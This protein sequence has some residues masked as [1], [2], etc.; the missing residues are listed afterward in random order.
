VA[1]PIKFHGY[2]GVSWM[3][4]NALPEGMQRTI[5]H[6]T[7]HDILQNVHR[8]K[9]SRVGRC[10][11]SM[12]CPCCTENYSNPPFLSCLLPAAPCCIALCRQGQS[13]AVRAEEHHPACHP[14][15]SYQSAVRRRPCAA[16][17]V[18]A[19]SLSA[20][21]HM[22]THTNTSAYS[23]YSMCSTRWCCLACLT[24]PHSTSIV[25]SNKLIHSISPCCLCVPPL[26]LTQ[27]GRAA[28]CTI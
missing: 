18:S 1:N 20:G 10:E 19:L 11:M 3:L 28:A 7:T 13:G 2:Q 5:L 26:A 15:A 27:H 23:M 12:P 17:T 25:P 9:G 6:H 4:G 21:P 8:T 24:P 22:Y 14:D 16:A